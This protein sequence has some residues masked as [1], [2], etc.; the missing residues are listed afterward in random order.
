[1]Y[2]C[3]LPCVAIVY[4]FSIIF[5]MVEPCAEAKHDIDTKTQ[6]LLTNAYTAAAEYL[7]NHETELHRL[8]EALVEY[9]TLSLPEVQLAIKCALLCFFVL[10][11]AL[12][13]ARPPRSGET[14][15]FGGEWPSGGCEALSAGT[16]T[17]GSGGSTRDDAGGLECE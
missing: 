6:T 1:M 16:H 17:S 9:E 7:K 11:F 8:A 13:A 15:A 14:G 12:L 5:L 2:E 10:C 4:I 3:M